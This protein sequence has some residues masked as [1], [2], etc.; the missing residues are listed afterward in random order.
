M[1]LRKLPLA[2]ALSIALLTSVS[3]TALAEDIDLSN[4]LPFSNQDT[5]IG[6]ITLQSDGAL[7]LEGNRWVATPGGYTITENTVLEFEFSSTSQGEIHG[8]GFDDDN[9]ISR[10]KIFHL[11]GTQSWGIDNQATYTA[12]NG[13]FQ[14]FRIPVGQF[15]TGS[16]MQLVLVNDDDSANPNNNGTFRNVRLMDPTQNPGDGDPGDGNPGDGEPPQDPPP[17]DD[18]GCMDE[19]QRALLEAHNEVRSQGY[20]CGGT[21]YAPAPPLTFSCQL[22]EAAERHST[23]MANNNHFSHTGTDGSSFTDRIGDTGYRYR[24]GGENIAAGQRS[25]DSVMNSWLNSSGHC[26]NI[27]NPSFTEYGGSL[28][29]SSSS[30]YSQYWTS[31]FATPR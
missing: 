25:V 6:E 23:D 24:T 16:G 26:R 29:R 19:F 21:S 3:A 18:N 2:S 31:V 12:Q 4:T 10:N 30:T 13:E 7:T 5:G 17:S 15:Y 9:R 27:M 14:T 1:Y 20:N 8:I 28:V 11:H 22:G